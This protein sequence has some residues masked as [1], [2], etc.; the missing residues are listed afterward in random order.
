VGFIRSLPTTLVEAFR[1]TLEEVTEASLILHVV[2]ASSPHAAA[3]VAHVQK[4][5]HEIG[6]EPIPQLH[7]LNKIDRPELELDTARV[8]GRTIS[9]SALTGAGIAELLAVVD[10]ILPFDPVVRARFRFP[11][12]EG[13]A[14]SM[15]HAA[16]RVLETRYDDRY[17]EVEAEV[18]ESVKRRLEQWSVS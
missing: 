5:L 1:A 4:V 8:E 6:A 17:C 9:I 16:G 7:V 18:S 3:H 10:E 14:L 11:I 2:D 15:L 13:A 12:G